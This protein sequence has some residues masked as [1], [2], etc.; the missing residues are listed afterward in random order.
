MN[1]ADHFLEVIVAA[2]VMSEADDEVMAAIVLIDGGV[3]QPI[4]P[5]TPFADDLNFFGGEGFDEFDLVV[6]DLG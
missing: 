3:V 4:F 1:G 5:G 6:G 2:G